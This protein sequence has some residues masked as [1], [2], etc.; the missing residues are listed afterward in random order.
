[1]SRGR[2]CSPAK[3]SIRSAGRLDLLSPF[4]WPRAEV[5]EEPAGKSAGAGKAKHV[6]SRGEV[7]STILQQAH[8]KFAAHGIQDRIEGDLLQ[9][10]PAVQ[11]ATIAADL[12]G[13]ALDR[14]AA[15]RKLRTDQ[16]SHLGLE[17]CT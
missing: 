5:I 13:Q 2:S 9:C 3:R 15:G 7:G 17:R 6:R 10:E 16:L 14:A 11:C 1:M 8:G 4:G 12:K